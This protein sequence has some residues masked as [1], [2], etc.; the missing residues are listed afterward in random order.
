MA[1]GIN[2][3]CLKEYNCPQCKRDRRLLAYQPVPLAERDR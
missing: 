3:V 2:L 1:Y